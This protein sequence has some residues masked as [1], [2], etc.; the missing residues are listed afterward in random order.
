[1]QDLVKTIRK[2]INLSQEQIASLMGISPVTVNRWENGKVNPSL[3]AQK[4]LY[5]ICISHNLEFSDYIVAR[6][7]A[8]E[9]MHVLYHA[10]R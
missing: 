7:Q 9:N 6:E 5:D 2:K 10:S 4:Q 8:V 1:M 3:M